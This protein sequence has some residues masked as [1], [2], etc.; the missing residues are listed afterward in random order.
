MP[1]ATYW[2]GTI[3]YLVLG[4]VALVAGLVKWSRQQP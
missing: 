2:F 3:S 1:E 4:L